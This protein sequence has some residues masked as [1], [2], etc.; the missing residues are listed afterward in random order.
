[1]QI[2]SNRGSLT[3]LIFLGILIFPLSPIYSWNNYPPQIFFS[4]AMVHPNLNFLERS[5]D[6]A[7]HGWN[8]DAEGWTTQ[9]MKDMTIFHLIHLTP[10][11]HGL[12]SCFPFCHPEFVSEDKWERWSKKKDVSQAVAQSSVSQA[13]MWD[14][15]RSVRL[16]ES[17]FINLIL[18]AKDVI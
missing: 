11:I 5:K 17:H 12:F 9:G 18:S 14:P 10:S 13:Q 16:M 2:N 4:P 6:E 1:M 3:F 8:N 15:E 7:L